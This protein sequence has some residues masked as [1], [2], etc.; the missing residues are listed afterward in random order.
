MV[1]GGARAWTDQ[2][3]GEAKV[4]QTEGSWGSEE[5]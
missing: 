2:R 4:N 1:I 5:T 3:H